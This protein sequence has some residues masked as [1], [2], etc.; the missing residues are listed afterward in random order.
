MTLGGRAYCNGISSWVGHY[1]NQTFGLKAATDYTTDTAQYN[2]AVG[3]FTLNALST[4]SYNV[5]VGSGSLANLVSATRH[6][7]FGVDNSIVNNTITN[8]VT[9]GH[10]V[11]AN[12]TNTVTFG[13]TPYPYNKFLVHTSSGIVDLL[14]G[15]ISTSG[16]T[17]GSLLDV[18][19]TNPQPNDI[20]S[21]NGTYWVNISGGGTGGSGFTPY[22]GTGMIITPVGPNYLFTVSD[23][24]SKTEVASMSAALYSSLVNY[25]L[26]IGCT[27]FT[28]I[29][30]NQ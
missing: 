20:L 17:L 11:V 10:E 4:G 27:T 26:N 30:R 2:T 28:C 12:E 23:Y 19:I 7:S 29:Y 13:S 15:T 21:F 16:F 6:L 8:T 3:Y 25:I 5:A 9:V 14:T 24:I 18:V 22:A 1:T